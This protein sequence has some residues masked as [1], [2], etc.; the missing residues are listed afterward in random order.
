MAP[1]HTGKPPKQFF[2]VTF[3]HAESALPQSSGESE[4]VW[5]WWKREAIANA[6]RL[7]FQTVASD[8]ESALTSALYTTPN[9]L[10]SLGLTIHGLHFIRFQIFVSEY[11]TDF[12]YPLLRLEY[13]HD[14]LKHTCKTDI[15]TCE[16]SK[17]F[18]ASGMFYRTDFR[19]TSV[20]RTHLAITSHQT[21]TVWLVVGWDPVLILHVQGE[22]FMARVRF[23][24]ASICLWCK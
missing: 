20:G 1:C 19:L 15:I 2:I 12:L 17:H 24:N 9:E 16:S 21:P 10:C 22:S 3:S 7:D 8:A 18:T 5:N 14:D 11:V 6:E 13:I 23:P 4:V